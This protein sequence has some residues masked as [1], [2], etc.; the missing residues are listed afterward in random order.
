MDD[1]KKKSLTKKNSQTK[2]KES[3]NKKIEYLEKEIELL[4]KLNKVQEEQ[5]K[6]FHEMVDT[7]INTEERLDVY[8][9]KVDGFEGNFDI[10]SN[11]IDILFEDIKKLKG[12][13]VEDINKLKDITKE[14]LGVNWPDRNSVYNPEG[15]NR[16]R[17]R[18]TSSGVPIV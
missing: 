11:R 7:A 1:V 5:N 9:K 15:R 17:Q 8:A 16:G 18:R 6:L 10:I 14:K 4:A 3:I 13:L 2:K 12:I